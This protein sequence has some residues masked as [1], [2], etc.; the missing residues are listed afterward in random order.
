MTGAARI[1]PAGPDDAAA[2]A[3]AHCL[4]WR[5]TYRGMLPD[6]MVD[7]LGQDEATEKWTARLGPHAPDQVF[8][9]E[10]SAG[11]ALGFASGKP[12]DEAADPDAGLLDTLYLVKAGQGLGLGRRLLYTV[13]DMLD[14]AGYSRMLVV[15]HA[16]NPAARFYAAMG[17]ARLLE[18]ERMFRGHLCPEI[19]W[20]WALPLAPPEAP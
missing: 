19:L 7:G 8:I 14:T 15:V 10:D 20:S 6:A 17:A 1:R 2:I 11:T 9:A 12:S 13:A 4:A 16:E 18:R 5:E 3:A